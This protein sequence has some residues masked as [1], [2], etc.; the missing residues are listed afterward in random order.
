F[1]VLMNYVLNLISPEHYFN[2]CRHDILFIA[3]FFFDIVSLW[4]N[5]WLS[6]F[7]CMKVTNFPNRLFLWLKRRINVLTF[8]M[9]GMSITISM[10]FS[11]PSAISYYDKKKW[12]NMTGMQPM[13]AKQP[14]VCKDINTLFLLPQ[15]CIFSINFLITIT[16]SIVLIASLWRHIRNLRESGSG[17]KDLN[18][19]VHVNVIKHVMFFIFFYLIYFAGMIVYA[20]HI[21][22]SREI[23]VLVSDI[24][25]SLLPS[26]HSIMLLLTNP[27]M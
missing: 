12:C 18:T 4:C 10:I 8:K 13:A 17:V 3:W 1:F 15:L 22:N 2:S 14:K 24:L 27:K 20:S 23:A 21:V 25:L 11:V 16:A 7:Y 6:V 26:S 9:L 5:T 19:Q